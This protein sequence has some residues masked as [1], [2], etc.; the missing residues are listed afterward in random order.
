MPKV[1][2]ESHEKRVERQN[3]TPQLTHP[4]FYE[5]HEKRVESFGSSVINVVALYSRIS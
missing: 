3:H 5:S 2:I 4:D 1:T